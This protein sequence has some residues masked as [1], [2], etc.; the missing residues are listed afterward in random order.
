MPKQKAQDSQKEA[1][2][3]NKRRSREEA[4]GQQTL[5]ASVTNKLRK[6]VK[7]AEPSQKKQEVKG[8]DRTK[9]AQKRQDTKKST[10]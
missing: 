9:R 1:Q 3:P 7:I 8:S 6:V 4:M 10:Q 2:R 5:D